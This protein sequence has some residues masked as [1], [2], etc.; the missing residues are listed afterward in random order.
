MTFWGHGESESH[1]R[2]R[3]FHIIPSTRKVQRAQMGSGW[4]HSA[5]LRWCKDWKDYK[6]LAGHWF[7]MS[8]HPSWSQTKQKS[9]HTG[10]PNFQYLTACPNLVGWKFTV[11]LVFR[12]QTLILEGTFQSPSLSRWQKL[13]DSISLMPR[14]MPFRSLTRNEPQHSSLMEITNKSRLTSFFSDDLYTFHSMTLP[15]FIL[16]SHRWFVSRV[17]NLTHMAIWKSTETIAIR[18]WYL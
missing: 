18:A 16:L 5:R 4:I 11:S 13:L 17:C 1:T 7:V 6:D 2:R 9:T 10:R 3:K 14:L 8:H 12:V 15:N